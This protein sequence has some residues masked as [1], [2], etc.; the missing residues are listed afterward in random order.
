MEE[1]DYPTPLKKCYEIK[2]N[3]GSC[4]DPTNYAQYID[5]PLFIIQSTYDQYVISNFLEDNKCVKNKV[6]PYE[7][8]SCSAFE[9][10]KI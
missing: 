6:P 3:W 9:R 4:M 10:E 2:K 8:Q 5:A 1:E 7:I